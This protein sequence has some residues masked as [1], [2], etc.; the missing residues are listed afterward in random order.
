M[1]HQHS[2]NIIQ[3]N[4]Q[5]T[6]SNGA[7]AETLVF[8]NELTLVISEHT[9]AMFKSQQQVNDP[10]GNGLID[11]VQLEGDSTLKIE[12]DRLI[13]NYQSGF[14]GLVDGKAILITPNVIQLFP[15]SNDAL[16]NQNELARLN[17][18]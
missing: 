10:L 8:H 6:L 12:N 4:S 11:S 14:V 1:I 7:P 3:A 13:K 17:L 16:R 9:L 18:G 15:S 2:S 5:I